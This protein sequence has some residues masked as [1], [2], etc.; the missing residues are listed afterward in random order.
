[1]RDRAFGLN[2]AERFQFFPERW[3]IDP[4]RNTAELMQAG[5]P[6]IDPRTG[7]PDPRYIE[8]AW[9][10]AGAM[11]GGAP[12]VEGAVGI[13]GGEIEKFRA[14]RGVPTRHTIA[15]ARTSLP[16]LEDVTFEGASPRVRDEAGLPRATPG[17]IAS[18]SR[19]V[20][21]QR[22]AEEDIAN[23]FVRAVE[24]RGLKPSDLEGHTLVIDISNPAGVCPTCRQGLGTEE[25]PGVL[26]QLSQR[27]PGLTIQVSVQTQPGIRARGPTNFAIKNGRYVSGSSQ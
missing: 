15:V 3:F 25:Q 14:R 16:G 22:H 12:K 8:H 9:D 2:G 27:Y 26:K 18:P 23:Q 5:V 10:I 21:H 13:F 17:P 7:Q 4:F 20:F 11:A 24:D 6:V 19:W 1:M